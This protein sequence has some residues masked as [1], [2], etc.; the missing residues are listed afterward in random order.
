MATQS[1]GLQLSNNWACAL[2]GRLRLDVYKLC[3]S[4]DLRP[5]RSEVMSWYCCYYRLCCFG[6]WAL[7]GYSFNVSFSCQLWLPLKSRWCPPSCRWRI[8]TTVR[9]SCSSIVDAVQTCS[10]F[11]TNAATSVTPIWPAS[12]RSKCSRRIPLGFTLI[13]LSQMT[14]QLRAAYERVRAGTSTARS[15][16]SIGQEERRVSGKH[17]RNQ[18]LLIKERSRGG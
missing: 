14:S 12:T 15:P 3:N 1:W 13:H 6:R 7:D 8:V 18:F 10:L 17:Q 16:G 4:S 9:I 2:I 11:C 5:N